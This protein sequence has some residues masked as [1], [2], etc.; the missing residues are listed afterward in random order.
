MHNDTVY[1]DNRD[2]KE[3]DIYV[4]D[5]SVGRMSQLCMDWLKGKGFDQDICNKFV[6]EYILLTQKYQPILISS[7]YLFTNRRGPC[8]LCYH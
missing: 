4:V 6:G 3:T 8:R 5:S 1:H 2:D 7:F